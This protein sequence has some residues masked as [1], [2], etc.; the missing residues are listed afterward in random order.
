MS[1]TVRLWSHSQNR[2]RTKEQHNS[3]LFVH[4]PGQTLAFL[5]AFLTNWRTPYNQVKVKTKGIPW[6]HMH[7]ADSYLECDTSHRKILSVLQ[8]AQILSDKCCWVDQALSSFSMIASF[9]VFASHVL[10][11]GQSQVWRGLIA[12]GNS[13]QNRNVSQS[14]PA[15]QTWGSSESCLE[16]TRQVPA[17][18]ST[19]YNKCLSGW[20]MSWCMDK[21]I[22]VVSK[23]DIIMLGWGKQTCHIKSWL[24]RKLSYLN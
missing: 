17:I 7:T 19:C 13:N 22:T 11:P 8:H 9:R 1:G 20:K 6:P 15:S 16:F 14:L 21:E 3:A 23:M 18:T 5:S 10:Q 2:C 12:L 4:S 24:L